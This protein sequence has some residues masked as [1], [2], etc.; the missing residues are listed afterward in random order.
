ML[1]CGFAES[2]VLFVRLAFSIWIL[3]DTCLCF[4]VAWARKS[5]IQ[6]T[7]SA[8]AIVGSSSL[9]H[10]GWLAMRGGKYCGCGEFRMVVGF[11][12]LVGACHRL[13]PAPLFVSTCLSGCSQ[14]QNCRRRG[15][16]RVRGA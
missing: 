6:F 3:V 11:W 8:A 5:N 16:D 4:A 7:Y 14:T 15:L 2:G 9:D 1:Q 10:A 12:D 13:S